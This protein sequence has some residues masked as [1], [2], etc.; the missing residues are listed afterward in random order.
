MLKIKS[1]DETVS[2]ILNE[3]EHMHRLKTGALIKAS[4]L[5]A[6]TAS[7]VTN[8]QTFKHFAHFADYIGLAFQIRDDILDIQS[9]TS[10]LGKPQG[11]D[12]AQNKPTYP[13][14]VG[15]EQSERIANDLLQCALQELDYL[16]IESDKLQTVSHY[17]VTRNS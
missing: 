11:S 12:I 2:Q 7:E 10:V 13:S 6:V 1:N 8:A 4:V 3:I 5:M 14:I 9:E 15:L 17:M 16:D